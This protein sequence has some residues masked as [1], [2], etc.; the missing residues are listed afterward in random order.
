MTFQHLFFLAQAKAPATQPAPDLF[1]MLIPFLC[2]GVIFYFLIIRPQKKKQQDHAKLVGGIKSGDDVVLAGG[3]HG[4]VANVK[5]TTFVV[6]IA[7]NTKI[8]VDKGSVD[9][10][11]AAETPDKA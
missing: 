9:R 1:G 3:I 5:E 6:K 2:L 11:M 7:E 8:E 10:V 4:R